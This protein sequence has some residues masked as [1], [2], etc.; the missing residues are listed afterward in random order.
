MQGAVLTDLESFRP[1]LDN[2][3]G[4]V[5]DID[6]DSEDD[7]D[8]VGEEGE[9][10][11]EEEDEDSWYAY[12]LFRKSGNHHN[13]GVYSRNM[14]EASLDGCLNMYGKTVVVRSVSGFTNSLLF[15]NFLWVVNQPPSLAFRNLVA[16]MVKSASTVEERN[17]YNFQ[18][19]WSL[20]QQLADMT[21]LLK[22]H[23][24]R[25]IVVYV[26]AADNL[27]SIYPDVLNAWLTFL[28]KVSKTRI[29][30]R[31]GRL[32]LNG[33]GENRDGMCTAASLLSKLKMFRERQFNEMRYET[34]YCGVMAVI[35]GMLLQARLLARITEAFRSGRNRRSQSQ[36]RVVINRKRRSEQPL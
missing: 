1:D 14:V 18:F 8:A 4:N 29:F 28:A 32:F 26:C 3:T 24:R 25:N 2:L 19:T 33:V 16:Q 20:L 22:K 9:E 31:F 35:I 12:V 13:G 5:T 27:P 11:E 10:K 36:R 6:I 21:S 23:K 30:I 17:R 34:H 7:D 15:E